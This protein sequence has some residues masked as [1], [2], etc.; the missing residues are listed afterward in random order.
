MEWAETMEQADKLE[1]AK[2]ENID[3]GTFLS[4]KRT[5]AEIV[6]HAL[7]LD[8]GLAGQPNDDT[9]SLAWQRGWADAQE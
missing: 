7:R 6:D 9:K 3:P 1:D 4:G 8:A 2:V 5:E